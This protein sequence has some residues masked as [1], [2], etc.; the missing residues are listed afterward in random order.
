MWSYYLT[1]ASL[2]ELVLKSVVAGLDRVG[3]DFRVGKDFR[4]DR[5]FRVGKDFLPEL[6]TRLVAL[7]TEHLLYTSYV[8]R[9]LWNRQT[10]TNSVERV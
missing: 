7:G 3:M 2:M 8:R 4:V 1:M 9:L 6:L 5:D 10:R